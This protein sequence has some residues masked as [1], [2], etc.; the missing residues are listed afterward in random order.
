MITVIDVETKVT[1]R[2]DG[3]IDGSPFNP[4]NYLVSCGFCHIEGDAFTPVEYAFFRHD[5]LPQACDPEAFREKVQRALDVTSLLVGHNI[6]YDLAWL[7]ESGFQYD[8]PVYDTMVADYILARGQKWDLS[9][10]A[11]AI[12]RGAKGKRKDLTQELWDKGIGFESMPIDIVEQ[13]GRADIEATAGVYLE[14]QRLYQDERNIGLRP[15]LDMSMELVIVLTGIYRNGIAIDQ[16]ALKLVKKEYEDEKQILE[17][18]LQEIVSE[19]MGD[20]PINLASGEQLS[21][22]VYSRRVL[23][24][25]KWK[26][27]FN[28][29]TDKRG[30]PLKPPKMSHSTFGDL[31]MANTEKMRKTIAK[32]CEACEGRGKVYRTKKNGDAWAKPTLCKN[33]EGVGVLYIPQTSYAGFRMSPRNPFDVAQGGFT[34]DKET[35][36][37]LSRK[38]LAEGKPLAVEFL[39]GVV[40]LNAIDTYL[41]SFVGGIQRG[42]QANGMLHFQLNQCTTSTGR[43]SSSEPNF[44]NQPR[45]GTFPIK[46]CIVSRFPGGSILEGDFAQLEFRCAGHL[47]GDQQII[48]DVVNGVDV[49]TN[50]AN[51]LTT[52]GQPTNRQG[53]KAHTFKPLYGGTTG[54]PAEIAYYQWFAERYAET[55]RWHARLQEEAI[56][57]K[58]ITLPTGRQ[59]AFPDVQRMPWGGSSHATQIKNYPVQGFATGDLVPCSAILL[60]WLMQMHGVKSLYI[61]TVHDSHVVDVYPGEEEQMIDI[62]KAAMTG[63]MGAVRERYGI[64]MTVPV[65]VEIKIGPNWLNLEKVQ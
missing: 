27:I 31:V 19:V 30:K 25:A 49:H 63:V 56:K 9:L 33:C 40:R 7:Q 38:A 52:A 43:L 32:Q 46:R 24:K 26:S 12:R 15:T 65:E 22:V 42:M 23:D 48:D 59:Y 57:F 58:L 13:Y 5:A 50:T 4:G 8:G 1:K 10:E 34:T 55:T 39:S 3:K 28:I 6:K 62:M 64:V 36:S 53:A 45:G 35:L 29:G 61:N 20:S 11:T 37:F 14:Q 51:A 47:S 16:D 41:T 60:A 18:R 44:Q 2:D 17:T 54:T 21:T